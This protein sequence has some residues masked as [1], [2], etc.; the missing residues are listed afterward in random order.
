MFKQR[1]KVTADVSMIKRQL[2]KAAKY[3]HVIRLE[4]I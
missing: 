1:L 2:D 3:S 4:A